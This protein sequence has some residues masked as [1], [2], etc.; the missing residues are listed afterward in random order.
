[1][2]EGEF[3]RRTREFGKRVARVCDALSRQRS[4]DAIARQQVRSGLSVGAGYRAA[5]RAKSG[6]DM[7]AKLAVEEEADESVHW[8]EMLVERGILPA[9]RL[10][11]LIQ[12]GNQIV[13]MTAKTLRKRFGRS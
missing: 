6:R 2:D 12:E 1:M 8:L 13:A 4:A 10:R 7:T 3:M 5:C 11:A 9:A